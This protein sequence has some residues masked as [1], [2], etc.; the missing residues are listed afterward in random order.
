MTHHSR[1]VNDV[2]I[3]AAEGNMKVC[4]TIMFQKRNSQLCYPRSA[5]KKKKKENSCVWLRI[6]QCCVLYAQTN[7]FQMQSSGLKDCHKGCRN[8]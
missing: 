1:Y 2:T 6:K 3:E 5:Q 8:A 4:D 7:K